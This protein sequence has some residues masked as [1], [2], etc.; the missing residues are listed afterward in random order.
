MFRDSLTA[1]ILRQGPRR[2]AVSMALLLTLVFVASVV[3]A[4]LR[5]EGWSTA[6]WWPA[7]GISVF[8]VLAARG[9]G[10]TVSALVMLVTAAANM[11][12]GTIW[13]VA[14]GFGIANACEAWIVAAIM[15]YRRQP[16]RRFRHPD[17]VRF[18]IATFVGACVI[19]I[20]AGAI[21][22]ASGGDL[23]GTA[24]AVAASHSSAPFR[25]LSSPW[26]SASRSHH[27][28]T[29]RWYSSRSRYLRG[30]RSGSPQG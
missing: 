18:I 22:A 6:P 23:L 20:L 16:G 28:R 3:S 26:P 15:R 21:V 8:A 1:A 12:A 9:R 2:H 11:A 19:G 13:W 7:A 25:C 30:R 4:G 10:F 27:S 24:V 17:S 5:F 14:I 29:F